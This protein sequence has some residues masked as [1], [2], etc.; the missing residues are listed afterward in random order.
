MQ[1]N[2]RVKFRMNEKT[3]ICVRKYELGFIH[4][5]MGPNKIRLYRLIIDSNYIPIDIVDGR[6][7]FGRK[8]FGILNV[9]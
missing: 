7:E 2:K 3:K 9:I 6:C 5:V 8:M 4:L 1:G